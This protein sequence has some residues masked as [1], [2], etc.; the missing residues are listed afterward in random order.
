MDKYG[1]GD[2]I[3]HEM[4]GSGNVTAVDAAKG[5]VEVDFDE[6]GSKW[7]VVRYAPMRRL[8]AAQ[9][10]ADKQRDRALFDETFV[11]EGE[12]AQHWLGSHWSPFYEDFADEVL[13]RL[14]EILPQAGIAMGVSD[15]GSNK[16]PA[17]PAGW[18][19][20][21]K[22]RWPELAD[23]IH[24][25][26]TIAGESNQLQSFFPVIGRGTQAMLAIENVNVWASGVEAQVDATWGAASLSFFDTDFVVNAGWYRKGAEMDFILCGLA[27]QC[28]PSQAPDIVLEE[29]H[30]ALADFR[31]LAAMRGEDPD[32]APN[33]ISMKGAAMLLPVAGRD[34]DDYEF[35]GTVREVRPYRMLGQSG[36]LLT[37]CVMRGIEDDREFDLRILAT[38]RSWR[39]D[40][41]PEVGGDVSG[42]LW[43]QGRLWSP[44]RQANRNS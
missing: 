42:S 29:G 26:L 25:V 43:L 31:K 28:G 3:R 36:W 40:D 41:P 19:K 10:I 33:T 9:E 20:A 23:A 24:M 37:V 5:R 38:R 34:R 30:P 27:Y 12:N 1:V 15:L 35:H 2:R 18:P 32:D 21:A 22:L 11:F 39:G 16:A 17:L 8:D 4:F 44:R 13:K 6:Y 7:L 14:P